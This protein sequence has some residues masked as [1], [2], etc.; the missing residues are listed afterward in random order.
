MLLAVQSLIRQERA[1]SPGRGADRELTEQDV[2]DL[3]L[4][5]EAPPLDARHRTSPFARM[6]SAVSTAAMATRRHKLLQG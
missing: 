6:P 4:I 5:G 3:G 2:P 1:N